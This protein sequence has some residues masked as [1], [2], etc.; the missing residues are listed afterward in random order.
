MLANFPGLFVIGFPYETMAS[1]LNLST[2]TTA[3]RAKKLHVPQCFVFM[4]VSHTVHYF[5]VETHFCFIRVGVYTFNPCWLSA[6]SPMFCFFNSTVQ[7][8]TLYIIFW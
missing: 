5:P 4:Y 7:T 8:V 3:L 1:N 6:C 2:K